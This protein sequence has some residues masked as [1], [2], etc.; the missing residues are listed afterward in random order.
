[1]NGTQTETTKKSS[2]T[3]R[4]RGGKLEFDPSIGIPLTEQAADLLIAQ[5]VPDRRSISVPVPS[6]A[7]QFSTSSPDGIPP[8]D[9]GLSAFSTLYSPSPAQQNNF[10]FSR[11]VIPWKNLSLISGKSH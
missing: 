1:M 4:R 3:K 5:G 6:Y 8:V 10:R 11:N 2:P 9:N 7:A